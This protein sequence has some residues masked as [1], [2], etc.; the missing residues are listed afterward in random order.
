MACIRRLSTAISSD[1]TE[2][3]L[4]TMRV[5]VRAVSEVAPALSLS[6]IRERPSMSLCG[7][8]GMCV[9]QSLIPSPDRSWLCRPRAWRESRKGTYEGEM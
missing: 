9:I 2:L 6:L 4:R 3:S 5:N 8:K 7:Q 1:E